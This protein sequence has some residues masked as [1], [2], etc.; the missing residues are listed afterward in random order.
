MKGKT[1]IL[2]V[3]IAVAAVWI[4]AEALLLVR[5]GSGTWEVALFW[6][7]PAFFALD[8]VRHLMS[9]PRESR[10]ALAARAGV[11]LVF[12]VYASLRMIAVL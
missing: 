3:Q 1:A 9:L 2:A 4:T 7:V 12:A 11:I 8:M 5:S 10:P 6:M